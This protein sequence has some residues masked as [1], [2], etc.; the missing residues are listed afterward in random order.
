M[1]AWKTVVLVLLVLALGG[2]VG[3]ALLIHRGFRATTEPSNFE[4]GV[5][6]AVRDFAIPGDAR[7]QKNPLEATPQNLDDGRDQYLAHC[8]KC[9][10]R[11]GSGLTAVGQSLY[12][13]APDLRSGRTQNLT[14]GEIH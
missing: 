10:G 4:A 3:T 7:R 1:K 6:R 11:D 9:H 5:A 13:R 12:P 8:A 2:A 14:D